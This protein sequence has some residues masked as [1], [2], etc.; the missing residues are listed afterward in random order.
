[1]FLYYHSITT[2]AIYHNGKRNTST[3]QKLRCTQNSTTHKKYAVESVEITPSVASKKPLA[4]KV[5]NKK[6][7]TNNQDSGKSTEAATNPTPTKQIICNTDNDNGKYGRTNY[8]T[9]EKSNNCTM[10]YKQDKK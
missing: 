7:K 2:S 10:A 5:V 4:K 3:K 8:I 6:T 1:M 9:N